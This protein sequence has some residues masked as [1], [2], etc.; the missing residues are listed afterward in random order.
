MSN[1]LG[2]YTLETPTALWSPISL[3]SLCASSTGCT[4][5]LKARPNPP[6][7]RP[8]SFFSAFLKMPIVAF[9]RLVTGRQNQRQEYHAGRQGHI[10]EQRRELR[11]VPPDGDR[12]DAVDR[13]RRRKRQR[14]DPQPELE[15]AARAG[16]AESHGEACPQEHLEHAGGR[17]S[18]AEDVRR[19]RE[20][21]A[22]LRAPDAP[23][24]RP[25][26]GSRLRP[27]APPS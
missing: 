26:R 18:H 9:L 14:P 3:A 8:S 11:G 22:R 27:L 15:T 1:S 12:H 23:V 4:L 21:V 6:S 10:P 16:E 20:R 2:T 7:T 24:G 5:A 13:E 19:H 25:R 17:Q